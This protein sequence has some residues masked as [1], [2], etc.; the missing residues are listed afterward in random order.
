MKPRRRTSADA[1]PREQVDAN[2][3]D[4]TAPDATPVYV[5]VQDPGPP[6]LVPQ[7]SLFRDAGPFNS[8][9]PTR[10]PQVDDNVASAS[11]LDA[12]TVYVLGEDDGNLWLEHGPFGTVP[13]KREQVEATRVSCTPRYV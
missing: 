6:S 9:P 8:T 2:V 7:F 12:A 1:P 4:F 5:K 11:P 3:S 13:P 10:G